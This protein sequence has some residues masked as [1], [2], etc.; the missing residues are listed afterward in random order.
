V[1]DEQLFQWPRI[2]TGPYGELVPSLE[3]SELLMLCAERPFGAHPATA[4]IEDLL[5]PN[6]RVHD[7]LMPS[8]PLLGAHD[9]QRR[10]QLG[11]EDRER[12]SHG[13]AVEPVD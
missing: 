1:S 7:R 5:G 9:H 3:G 10:S 11:A 4:D 8:R 13:A 6:P 12:I 2:G